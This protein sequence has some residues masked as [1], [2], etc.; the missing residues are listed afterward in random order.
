MRRILNQANF[1]TL[2][3]DCGYRAVE[4]QRRASLRSPVQSTFL[5][6]LTVRAGNAPP[7]WPYRKPTFFTEAVNT[8]IRPC[9]PCLSL[10][11]FTPL[12]FVSPVPLTIV[13]AIKYMYNIGGKFIKIL[14]KLIK[15]FYA[16]PCFNEV[17]TINKVTLYAF[18][19]FSRSNDEYFASLSSYCICTHFL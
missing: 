16:N 3:A 17:T 9:N 13:F 19:S 2:F 7:S 11:I 12:H 10:Y 14:W 15:D 1:L 4:W 5:V 8:S 6:I 18:V